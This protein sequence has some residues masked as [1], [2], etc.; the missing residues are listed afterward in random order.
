MLN[1]V[2]SMYDAVP[3][4]DGSDS[5]DDVKVHALKPA[6]V[7][8]RGIWLT[9]LSVFPAVITLL[10][11]VVGAAYEPLQIVY[12]NNPVVFPIVLVLLNALPIVTAIVGVKSMRDTVLF[13]H[14]VAVVIAVLASPS[15]LLLNY[16]IVGEDGMDSFCSGVESMVD[17]SCSGFATEFSAILVFALSFTY[18]VFGVC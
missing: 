8:Q 9:L 17:F 3:D 10:F 12:P 14:F 2:P 6:D 5:D 1:V 4:S 15:I 7:R 18:I 16:H 11:V 13:V